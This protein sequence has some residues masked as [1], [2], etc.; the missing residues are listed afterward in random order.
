VGSEKRYR[1][2]RVA[3]MPSMLPYIISIN[4]NSKQEDKD[5][6]GLQLDLY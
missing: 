2:R 6:I 3:T 4:G 5:K 1:K